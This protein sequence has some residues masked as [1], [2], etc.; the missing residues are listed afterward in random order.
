MMVEIVAV[1][2]ATAFIKTILSCAVTSVGTVVTVTRREANR[3]FVNV[4]T[5]GE[6]DPSVRRKVT[7]LESVG[8]E[9]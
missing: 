6:V 4:A 2:P 1:L 3:P 8:I 5:P 7:I 9:M